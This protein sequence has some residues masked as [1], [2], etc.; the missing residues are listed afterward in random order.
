MTTLAAARQTARRQAQ[1]ATP[2]TEKTRLLTHHEARNT[3]H[4]WD[5]K[6]LVWLERQDTK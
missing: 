2:N 6:L 3:T 5:L 4:Q 1:Q